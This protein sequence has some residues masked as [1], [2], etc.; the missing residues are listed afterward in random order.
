MRWLRRKDREQEL[1]RE[2]RSDLEL[3][4]AEQVESGLSADEASCA[5]QRAFGNASVVKEEV[6]EVCGNGSL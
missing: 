5:A 3:E 2:I 4:T 6:R 1:E